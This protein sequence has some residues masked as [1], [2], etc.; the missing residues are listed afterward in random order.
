MNTQEIERAVQQFYTHGAHLLTFDNFKN[1]LNGQG[2]KLI[3]DKLMSFFPQLQT[4]SLEKTSLIPYTSEHIKK[5]V[6][7]LSLPQLRST[8]GFSKD[9]SIQS[10]TDWLHQQHNFY[11]WAIFNANQYVGNLSIRITPEQQMGYLEIYLG[12][13]NSKGQGVGKNSMAMII[14]WAFNTMQLKRIELITI[15]GNSVA[16]KLYLNS[17]F[18]LAKI[19]RRSQLIDGNYVNHHRWILVNK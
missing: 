19:K 2:C 6:T 11:L 17:G 18:V 13:N 1:K 9:I 5:T 16:E 3:I 8:F 12:E 4:L 10:H 14:E 7:W 15:E